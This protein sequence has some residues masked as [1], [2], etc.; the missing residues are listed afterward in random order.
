M[1]GAIYTGLTGLEAFSSGLQAVSNNVVNLNS[2]G[3]KS[4][5]VTFQNISTALDLGSRS[6]NSLGGGVKLADSTINYTAGPL[7]QTNQALDLAM[8]G[9]GF[10]MVMDGSQIRYVRTG[11]FAVDQNGYIA[12]TG[13][14]WRLATLDSTGKPVAVSTTPQNTYP[15]TATTTV[16]FGGNLS[17]SATSDTVSNIT[18]Y[19]ANGGAHVWQAALSQSNSTGAWTVAVTDDQGNTIGT[20]TLTFS[21]GAPTPDSSKL[22][23]TDSAN[24]LSVVFDFSEN[25]TSYSAGSTS[26]LATSSVDG[27]AAGTL[28][29]VTVDAQGQVSISYSNDKTKTLGAVAVATFRNPQELTEQ[30]AGQFTAKSDAGLTLTSTGDPRVGTVEAG[31]IEGSNV[32]LSKEFD[33]LII[34]Q[35]GYQASS[36]I[37]S[38]ANDMLQQLFNIRG[39]G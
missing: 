2:T 38:T 24:N 21:N 5:T 8:N 26:T 22:A 12:L 6:R 27:N 11:S 30:S 28:T 39:Q 19:D 37:V 17:S 25:V 20:Q 9:N 1:F 13:T 33:N 35:R 32:D 23:F 34:I 29:A 14:Q 7:Q 3:F 4:S 36:E 18:V 16:A 15:P 31:Y 10:L